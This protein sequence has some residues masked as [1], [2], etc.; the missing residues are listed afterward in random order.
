[1]CPS[2]P[3]TKGAHDVGSREPHTGLLAPRCHSAEMVEPEKQALALGLL[4]KGLG[5][6]LW[7]SPPVKEGI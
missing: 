6:K 7:L 2:P 1:M 3:A 5:K 4:L